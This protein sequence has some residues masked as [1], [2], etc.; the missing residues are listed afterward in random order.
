[1]MSASWDDGLAQGPEESEAP[2]LWDGLVALWMP[3]LG[4]QG[5]TLFDLSGHGYHGTLTNMTLDTAWAV[6]ELGYALDFDGTNDFVS[7]PSSIDVAALPFT[8][9]AW[10]FPRSYSDWRV[11]FGKRDSF[12]HSDMRFDVVLVINTG[13]VRLTSETVELTFAF[14]PPLNQW[15]ALAIVADPASTTLYV[16]GRVQE[17]LGAFTL[18]TDAGAAVSIGATDNGLSD[19]WNGRLDDIR[20]YTRAL[21]PGEIAAMYADRGAIL[22]RRRGRRLWPSVTAPSLGIAQE[23]NL[24]RRVYGRLFGRVN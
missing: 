2:E 4:A 11:I 7:L 19:R 12:L 10:I 5:G 6:G 22:R 24:F 21:T 18:G 23:R 8:V 14:S 17:T 3:S 15:T 16:D 9:S 13:G 20:L 1:M